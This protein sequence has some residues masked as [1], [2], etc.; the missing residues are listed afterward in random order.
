MLALERAAALWGDVLRSRVNILIDARFDPLGG[1]ALSATLGFAGPKTVHRDFPGAP[2]AATFYA[3]ALANR[4][5]A[6]DLAPAADDVRAR[7]NSDVDGLTVLGPRRFYYGLDGAPGADVDFVTVAL[8]EL[9]HGLGHVTFGDLEAGTKLPCDADPVAGCDDAYLLELLDAGITPARLADMSDAQRSTA[10]RD[11]PELVWA[12]DSATGATGSF[13]DGT[14]E[15]RRV[16]MHAPATFEPGSSVSHVSTSVAPN[17]L[18][19]PAYAGPIHDVTFT[20]A[21]LRDTGWRLTWESTTTST[22]STTLWSQQSCGDA[23]GNGSITSTDALFAL[24]TSVGSRDCSA[25]IC[26][27]DAS[28]SVTSTDALRILRSAVGNDVVLVCP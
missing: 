15:Q 1:D 12:G 4:F 14:D 27:V 6:V 25:S 2:R 24:A 11:E 10:A 8:H 22:T 20:A 3:A 21:V 19:E 28:G 7:F 26:D 5:A 18:M 13:A 9:A 16:R 23:D 17:E